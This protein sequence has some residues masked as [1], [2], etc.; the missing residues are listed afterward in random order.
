MARGQGRISDNE[1]NS[2]II[3]ELDAKAL[4]SGLDNLAGTGRTTE[5]VK[6]VNDA[7]VSHLVDYAHHYASDGGST[8]DYAITPNPPITAYVA[9]QTFNVKANTDNTGVA[10]LNVNTYG[11]KTIKKNHNEDFVTGDIV[12]GQIFTVVYDAGDDTFQITSGITSK[13]WKEI[14]NGTLTDT[15]Q[16]DILIPSNFNRVRIKAQTKASTTTNATLSLRFNND[17][18]ANHYQACVATEQG[19]MNKTGIELYSSGFS[20]YSLP[21]SDRGYLAMLDLEIQVDNKAELV[22]ICSFINTTGS[23]VC[24]VSG[25][26]V[27]QTDRIATI[28]LVASVNSIGAGSKVSVWGC[29]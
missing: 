22:G 20:A 16:F 2:G 11:A 18:T 24:P 29:E 17:S 26:W 6:G 21:K 4:Q 3:N 19:S 12:A 8:D 23:Y 10:T 25:L 14:F 9:G 7:L 27:N 13:T 28:N 5:T 1:L 15:P